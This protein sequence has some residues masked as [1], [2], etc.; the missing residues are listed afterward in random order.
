MN[1]DKPPDVIW[2]RFPTERGGDEEGFDY[3]KSNFYLS[4]LGLL[5]NSLGWGSGVEDG[6]ETQPA[7]DQRL[8]EKKTRKSF[9]KSQDSEDNE[10]V[11]GM[12]FIMIGKR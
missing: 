12:F 11:R 1:L 8:L 9:R 7:G 5:P 10:R 2:V 4:T 6:E 3:L